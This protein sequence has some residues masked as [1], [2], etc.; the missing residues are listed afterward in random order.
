[1][2]IKIPAALQHDDSQAAAKTLLRYFG[3]PYPGKAYTGAMFDNWDST[4]T[5]EADRDVFTADD[6]VAVSLLSVEAG[7]IA[8]REILRDRR[9]EF[10]GLLAC[11]GPDRDLADEPGPIDHTWP[12][13][14]LEQ[15]LRTVKGIGL[16][17]ASKLVARKRPR[18]Y[19]IWDNVVVDVL[20]TRGGPHTEPIHFALRTNPDLRR[21]LIAARTRAGLP[22][23]I[24]ELRI[25]DTLAWMQGSR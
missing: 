4:G 21:R 13:W 20:G 7:P 25:F 2:P 5:R 15:R 3:D 22:A 14:I 12:A 8:A 23:H 11:V 16:T 6:F 19:P 18:L 17:V 10:A 24:S 9:S 1:M